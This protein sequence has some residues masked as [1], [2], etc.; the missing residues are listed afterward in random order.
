MLAHVGLLIVVPFCL[1]A[2]WWQ[3]QRARSGNFLSWAY[4]LE[5]PLFAAVAAIMWWQVVHRGWGPAQDGPADVTAEASSSNSRPAR[6]REHEDAALRAYNDE[7]E[8]MASVAR[9][10]TWRNPRGLS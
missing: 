6:D 9:R 7:L 2:G 5:W 1:I 8:L 10:K 4:T 3:L